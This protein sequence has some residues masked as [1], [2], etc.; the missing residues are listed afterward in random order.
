MPRM[1]SIRLS[2]Y[3]SWA[4]SRHDSPTDRSERKARA[5]VSL[6]MCTGD[7]HHGVRHDQ[8]FSAASS[9]QI[10]GSRSL[11]MGSSGMLASDGI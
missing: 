10:S 4:M 2:P 8:H 3:K 5:R 11:R 6:I 1:L 9:F 7:E